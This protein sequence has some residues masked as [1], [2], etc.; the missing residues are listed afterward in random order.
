[1]SKELLRKVINEGVKD[2]LNSFFCEV[3]NT[4]QEIE[5]DLSAYDDDRFA[6]FQAIGEIVFNPNE[7]LVAVTAEVDEDLTERSAKK[8][9][10]EKVKKILKGYMKYDAGIFVFYDVAGSF[11]FSLVYGQ[12]EGTRKSWSNFRRFTYFVSRD[13][14]NNTFLGRVGTCDFSSLDI[15]KDAFSVEKVN[16]EFYNHIARFFYRLTGYD[17]KGEM[18]LPSVS[19][20]DKKT[21]QEFAVRLIGRTIFCWFLKHKEALI[22]NSILSSKAVIENSGYYHSI[23]EKLFFEVLNTSQE[24][25]PKNILP[26]ADIIPF[27]NGGLFEPHR[28]DFYPD[29]P[30]YN[31]V[32]PDNWF[33]QFFKILEQYNFTIDENSTVD[34]DVSVDPEMLGRIFENLLAEVNPETGETARK[35][36]GSYYT[37]RTIVD[38]MV[39]QSLKQYLITKT[40]IDD[41][42]IATLLSYEFSEVSLSESEKVSI[43]SALDE[44][45]IIDPACG[46]GAFPT[47][48]LHKMLLVLQKVDPDLKLWLKN[49]LGNIKPGIFKD[50]LL[51]R[52]KNE[53]WEYV[54]KLLIIQK[55]IYG[56]DIQTIAVE[57]SKL[58]FFLS[59]IVDEQIDDLKKNR[60]VEALPNLE[61]KFVAANS[62][63]RLPPVMNRQVG[64]G[65]VNEEVVRLKELRNKYLRSYGSEKKQI[66]EDFL[67]TRGKLIEQNVKWGGKD[68]LALQLANWNPFSNAT[69]EW[70][71]P[72]WMFG[73]DSFDI[74]IA[75]PPYRGNKGHKD[76][77]QIIQAGNLGIYYQR[78][79]DLFYFF[80]HLALNLGRQS[81]QIS[82]IT[83]NYYPTATSASRLRRDFKTRTIIRRLVNFNELKIFESAQ[84]QHNMLTVLSKGQDDNTTAE[85]CITKR[86]GDATPQVLQ[87]ILDWQDNETGY[88]RV[89]QKDLYDGVENY[90]RLSVDTE[91]SND[92][93]RRIL[94]KIK[95]QG[96]KLGEFCN[97]NQGIVSGADKI[98]R[99]HVE[100]FHLD[101]NIGDGIFI[102]TPDEMNRERI[103]PKSEHAKPWFKNSDIQQ[104]WTNNNIKEYV[105]YFK[106]KKFKQPIEQEVLRHFNKYKD[107]L[108]ARLS[109]CKK[110][111]FQWNIVSKWIDRGEYYLLFYPRKQ[112]I[113][114]SPKIVV[115][116][117]SPKNT[118]GYNEIPWYAASDVFFITE[119]D[120]A[121]SLKY[122]LALINSSLYY[123]WLYHRGKRKGEMLELIATPLSEIPIKKIAKI[124][125]KPFILIV[126]KILVITNDEAYQSNPTKQAKVKE[127]E[128]QIDQIVYELYGLTPEEIA[129]V[130]SSHK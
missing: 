47:G 117:R 50:R 25:R 28:D 29:K 71:D 105:L 91:S 54:R 112:E 77:F 52:I 89:L 58:R 76:E 18:K 120:N 96:N 95:Q 66:E 114:E 92:P 4:Y 21:Y 63:I 32:I 46:S 128:H 83:T 17:C 22:P 115:P 81:A 116:Q 16:K 103:D 108:M 8:A 11:R 43:I 85:T 109:V 39:D 34:A 6:N 26:D 121:I 104:Y 33:E 82:F 68:A 31:L 130:E 56:V 102:L 48:L 40:K 110:N 36:T 100:K 111:V 98:S 86:K 84:G 10:Y 1:M 12:A 101:A 38:Y 67:K 129:V 118:F 35:A 124:D 125:Q 5:D 19:D 113:F 94:Y 42:R 30:L 79:M 55:S 15:I 72:E 126:D 53:N 51:E 88:Y 24:Q 119:K 78:R 7:K 13:Q 23:L 20:D 123:L 57:I 87:N 106:D 75:N 60:G 99:R 9:Q 64:L 44:I 90:I 97:I 37:P 93:L 59:L 62:L 69:S 27:L 122:V 3:S 14:T 45:K 41:D 73:E 70:F 80:F 65:I 127:L 74:I 61:F 49:H 107:L 2:N